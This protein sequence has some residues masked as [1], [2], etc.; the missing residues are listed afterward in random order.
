M[1]TA[2]ETIWTE[3]QR[4]V[5]AGGHLP[6]AA[7]TDPA[8]FR[9][10]RD[11]I[12]R[13]TWVL[14]GAGSDVPGDGDAR[15]LTIPGHPMILLRRK[16]EVEVLSNVCL[17]RGA[18]VLTEPVKKAAVFTCPYHAWSYGLDGRLRGRPHFHGDGRHDRGEDDEIRLTPVRS[19]MW[20]DLV[21]VNLDGRAEP[22]EDFIAPLVKRYEG[23]DFGAMT[24][25][26]GFE[27]EAPGNWKLVAENFLDNYHIFALHPSID[28]SFGQAGRK[29]CLR[30]AGPLMASSY[31]KD[32]SESNYM[33]ALEPNPNVPAHLRHDN[34]FMGLFPNVLLHIWSY[35]IMA[36]Q[37]IPIA[38][39]R[40]LERYFFYFYGPGG[41]L[42]GEASARQQAMDN[43]R[44]INAE[45][46]FPIIRNMQMTREEGTFDQGVLSSFWDGMITDYATIYVETGR[47]GEARAA[48]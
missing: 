2:P 36:M 19:A 26:G 4:A 29:P 5:D 42:Q 45:E 28:A 14:A 13:R 41:E 38:P 32:V 35:T 24:Y 3:T 21:F 25:G 46:D 20:H 22:F 23:Y 48:A 47:S 9:H 15:P 7:Y 39:D 16:G 43:Y 17:H 10:E 27:I 11:L 12:F 30:D 34:T 37:L 40:T 18:C 8:Y 44:T 31:T 1:G 6:A 33:A